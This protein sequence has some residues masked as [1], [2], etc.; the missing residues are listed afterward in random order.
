MISESLMDNSEECGL[1]GRQESII[2]SVCC[3]WWNLRL[4]IAI[5]GSENEFQPI[6]IIL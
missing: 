1:A 2:G 5:S 3:V 4:G 6:L